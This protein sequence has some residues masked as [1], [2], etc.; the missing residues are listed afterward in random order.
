[1]DDGSASGSFSRSPRKAKSSGSR[2]ND[3]VPGSAP[4]L[5]K[6]K[7][8]KKQKTLYISLDMNRKLI[9]LYGEEGRRQSAIVEDAVNLYY[10]L[11]MALGDGR[12]E[13]LM[14]LVRREDP[15]LLRRYVEGLGNHP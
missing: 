13:E 7:R 10:Y 14:N 9:E 1:M 4:K 11:K 15:Q 8:E 3:H 12:F 6:L 5:N 2:D